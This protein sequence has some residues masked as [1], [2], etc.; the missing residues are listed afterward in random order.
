MTTEVESALPITM[1][2]ETARTFA[3]IIQ[4]VEWLGET[5]TPPVRLESA[6]ERLRKLRNAA[7]RQKETSS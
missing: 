3:D 7:I 5:K 2:S 4:I 6:F 1:D